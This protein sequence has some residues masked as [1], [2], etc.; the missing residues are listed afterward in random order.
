MN[1]S[2]R[3]LLAAFAIGAMPSGLSAIVTNVSTTAELVD[4]LSYLNSTSTNRENTIVLAKGEYDVSEIAMTNKYDTGD[5]RG[6]S[7][8]L[9]LNCV[10]LLGETVNPR[11]TVI[12]GGG[13]ETRLRVICGRNSAIR[14]LTVSNGWINAA[15]GG[16]Y[17][18]YT[19]KRQGPSSMTEMVSNCVVTCCYAWEEDGG[20]S[21]ISSVE[22]YH[23]EICGNT[24]GTP[25]CFGAADKC[26]LHKCFVH[27]NHA[28]A[29]GGGL[30]RCYAYDCVISNNTSEVSGAG[31]Y[32]GSTLSK[33]AYLISGCKV[34]DNRS[35]GIG[36]GITTHKGAP[37]YSTNTLFAGNIAIGQGGGAYGATC[38]SCTISNN[39]V[40]PSES[41]KD[42]YGAGV[43][44]GRLFGCDICFNHFPERYFST[45][46][47][48]GAGSYASSVTDCRVFG[49][50]I[51]GGS[52]NRQGAGL[53]GGGATNCVIYENYCTASGGGVAM[54]AGTANGCV[55]SNNQVR[56][57]NGD[58]VHVRQPSG[59]VV[60][61]T[62]Y[63]Q[64]IAGSANV[65][66]ENCRFTGY[67]DSWLIPAGHNIASMDEDLSSDSPVS[68]F[69]AS[70]YIHM[71]NCLVDDNVMK[72]ICE[73]SEKRLQ[74]FENCTFVNNKVDAMFY[75]Y[76]SDSFETN[77]AYVVNSIFTE[78]Y[79]KAGTKR[80]DLSFKTGS[81]VALENCV[82][83]T[84]RSGDTLYSE[85]GTVTADNV[86]FNRKSAVH[87]Y[88]IKRSSPAR[89][90][91][92]ILG[93]MTSESTDIRA[94][95]ACP[96]LRD[97]T[98]DIGCYQC[99]LDPAGFVMSVK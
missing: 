66:I 22:A 78:N 1:C 52:R 37:G 33:Y 41:G 3:C 97:G 49:N 59:P 86:K 87:P 27:S 69:V 61:C 5:F 43:S 67:R 79:N 15:P 89:G 9:A 44:S 19:A 70:S 56:T 91:G 81:N 58:T 76:K 45:G 14:N 57:S 64:S 25:D 16:G 60:N 74:T 51:F 38:Y 88:E 39:C 35:S 77:A 24:T 40:Y 8:H 55:F 6:K 34:V 84:S 12:F 50:A 20:G 73:A 85:T 99:W 93:W 31:I 29:R 98:V 95:P 11:D 36:G 26:N 28:K 82:V 7:C 18:A 53:Y 80:S 94:D 63:G 13:E 30:G 54:N 72:Y 62:F 83:G 48:Y 32:I 90:A 65:L 21:A 75:K 10:T 47:A 42:V 68:Y 46:S 17:A 71:R 2:F 4:V 92:K 96:R 23:S